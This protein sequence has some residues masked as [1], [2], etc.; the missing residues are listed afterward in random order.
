[1]AKLSSWST[2]HKY[3]RRDAS[4]ARLEA[5]DY[6][7]EIVKKKYFSSSPDWWSLELLVTDREYRC[8]G[9]ATEI[10]MWGTAVADEEGVFCGIEAS[11]AGSKLY[12][13][14]GFTKLDTWVV[15]VP[16]ERE[17][18]EYDVVRRD[19]EGTTTY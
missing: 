6:E 10:V 15:R 5:V 7:T 1:M 17:S 14:C 13:A 3:T 9:A 18:L 8:R 2:N 11:P 19:P 16:G 4:P 12:Q